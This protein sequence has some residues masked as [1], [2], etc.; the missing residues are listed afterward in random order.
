MVDVSIP[1][2]RCQRPVH[3]GD[4]FCES[5][6]VPVGD[7]ERDA[8]R[9]RLQASSSEA[10]EQQKHVRSARNGMAVLSGLFVLGGAVMFFLG[11]STA[12]KALANLRGLDEGMTYPAP[13]NGV[14][15]TVGE[16]RAVIEREPYQLLGVNFLLA[17]I[18]LGLFF[19]AKKSA[20]PATITALAVFVTVHVGNAIADPK[21]LAQG[22]LVKV[23]AVIVLTRGIRAALAARALEQ[24]LAKQRI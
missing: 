13:I 1:C 22:V 17:A 21:T 2:T 14:T 5:C 20:L 15:Y 18:M 6:G 12:E 11:Q 4:E 16:L 9:A 7:A 10:A 24:K 8:L 3:L 23:F 19:W